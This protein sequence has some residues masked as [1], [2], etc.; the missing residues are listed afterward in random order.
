MS[1]PNGGSAFPNFAVLQTLEGKDEILRNGQ[2]MTLRDWFCGQVIMG[3]FTHP[4]WGM[5]TAEQRAIA[6]WAQADALLAERGKEP[7]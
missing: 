1:R 6:A 7:T 4:N 5:A 3:M 2:G